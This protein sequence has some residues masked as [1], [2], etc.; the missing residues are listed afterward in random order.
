MWK[1]VKAFSGVFFS[2]ITRV[3]DA[4]LSLT[5]IIFDIFLVIIWDLILFPLGL[6]LL[7]SDVQLFICSFKDLLYLH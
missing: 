2:D 1:H 7:Q 4:P 5:L 6:Y 3:I